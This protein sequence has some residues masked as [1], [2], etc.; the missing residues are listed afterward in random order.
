MRPETDPRYLGPVLTTSGRDRAELESEITRLD[1]LSG[2]FS[3][4]GWGFLQELLD[5]EST[6]TRKKLTLPTGVKSLDEVYAQRERYALLQWLLF[7]PLETSDSL[8]RASEELFEMRTR[9]E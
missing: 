5:T 6:L 9:E 3:S 4:A 7:L 8:Q 2:M 1:A